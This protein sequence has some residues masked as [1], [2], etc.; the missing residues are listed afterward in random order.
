[1][2][3][4]GTFLYDQGTAF[5]HL[6][7][8]EVAVDTF[9]YTTSDGTETVTNT[10]S[11]HVSGTNDAVDARDSV[12][13]VYAEASE[14][15]YLNLDVPARDVPNSG[16]FYVLDYDQG[17]IAV[18]ARNASDQTGATIAPEN[19]IVLLVNPNTNS[20]YLEATVYEM[21]EASTADP[22]SLKP[23]GY[24]GASDVVEN[25]LWLFDAVENGTIDLVVEHLATPDGLAVAQLTLTG[26]DYAGAHATETA[27]VGGAEG[28]FGAASTPTSVVVVPDVFDADEAVFT[29]A[30]DLDGTV[31]SV[32]DNGDGTF[33]YDT[34]DAFAALDAGEIATD[35]FSYT[36]HEGSDPFDGSQA[37][38]TATVTITA[39]GTIDG[40]ADIAI[41]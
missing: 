4:D 3:E 18:V 7:E 30:L 23:A 13:S 20:L 41:A 9:R 19:G 35:T 24:E 40:G 22:A 34:L 5:A 15:G 28:T 33:T 11:V 2:N 39:I 29:F 36:V 31:G 25:Q 27:R 21:G 12:A 17:S 8:G 10:V 38:D 32:V 16:L 26:L 1:M 37:F 14:V 6:N